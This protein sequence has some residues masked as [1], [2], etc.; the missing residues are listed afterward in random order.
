MVGAR[1]NLGEWLVRDGSTLFKG[2]DEHA[3][4]PFL[5]V[6]LKA[7]RHFLFL[8][9]F[10]MMCRTDFSKYFCG[11][12]HGTIFFLVIKFKI[13]RKNGAEGEGR[14]LMGLLPQASETCA[15]ANS[16]TSANLPPKL[17]LWMIYG[18]WESKVKAVQ[19]RLAE[20]CEAHTEYFFWR[21][22]KQDRLSAL[23]I[24]F[25]A[26]KVYRQRNSVSMVS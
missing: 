25:K 6:W 17:S 20:S 15:Y 26:P 11:S 2:F 7:G 1:G 22:A 19:K 5:D 24:F 4:P 10:L 12:H 8:W 14:T 18:F 9:S 23:L 16:A 21:G 13:L 3:A